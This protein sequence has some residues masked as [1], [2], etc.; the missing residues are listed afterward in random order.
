VW[1][2]VP[3][4]ACGAQ[5]WSVTHGPACCR[6]R[7]KAFAFGGVHADEAFFKKNQAANGRVPYNKVKEYMA[8]RI[9]EAVEE[10]KSQYT[11]LE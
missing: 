10:R 2:A 9:Y 5:T 3:Q 11:T 4:R 7:V 6:R 8:T 1:F